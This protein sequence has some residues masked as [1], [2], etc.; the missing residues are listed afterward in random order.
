M[1]LAC[2]MV[3]PIYQAPDEPAH[4]DR[5]ISTATAGFPEYDE[6]RLSSE[7]SA[8]SQILGLRADPQ[9]LRAEDAPARPL[10]TFGSLSGGPRDAAAVNQLADHPPLYYAL[11]GGA[12]AFVTGLLPAGVWQ[13][14][15]DVLLLRVLNA[16]LLVGLPW[17]LARTAANLRMAP[18]QTWI[19]AALPLCIPQ[20]AHIGAAVNNDN[21]LIVASALTTMFASDV[22]VGGLR[23][24]PTM[25]M[26]LAAGT[27]IQTKIFGWALVPLVVVVCV[28]AL[29]VDVRRWPRV[30]TAAAVI[31]LMGWTYLRNLAMYGHPYPAQ[32][33][34]DVPVAPSD[35]EFHAFAF[36]AK[37]AQNTTGSFF[38][39]FGWL[40]LPLP[41]WWTLALALVLGACMVLP[42]V[43]PAVRAFVSC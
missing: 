22:L 3:V 30:L 38:G 4:V 41:R 26:A 23:W 14:D 21:L 33:S 28:V 10:P 27:A 31:G 5:I 6:L 7:V 19:A 13:L 12:R 18:W 29:R 32:A 15:R 20:M 37:L 17:I 43:R 2:L 35:F 1:L 25:G 16:L 42:L 34:A 36:L 9:P 8:S 39:R 40:W 11:M 24:P